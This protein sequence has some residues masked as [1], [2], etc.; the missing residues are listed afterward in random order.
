MGGAWSGG[1][2][3][4]RGTP[5]SLQFPCRHL[6][7]QDAPDRAGS[8]AWGL[9]AADCE[10]QSSVADKPPSLWCFVVAARAKIA[11]TLLKSFLDD[12]K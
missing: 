5:G 10:P 9:Q 2:T 11:H 4:R 6:K 12:G 8:L 1:R 7:I 3:L